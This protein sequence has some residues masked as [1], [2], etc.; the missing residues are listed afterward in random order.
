MVGSAS[1]AATIFEKLKSRANYEAWNFQKKYLHH[2][3][4]LWNSGNPTELICWIELVLSPIARDAYV[5]F[6]KYKQLANLIEARPKVCPNEQNGLRRQVGKIQNLPW[7]ANE[8][9]PTQKASR[10][11]NSKTTPT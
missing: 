9:K 11:Q 6:E 2:E 1:T 10:H 7:V 4:T 5:A 3:E 8:R